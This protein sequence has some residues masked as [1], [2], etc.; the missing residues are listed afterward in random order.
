MRDYTTFS[1]GI[2]DAQADKTYGWVADNLDSLGLDY[3]V[4]HLR[5]TL[6]ASDYYVAGYLSVIFS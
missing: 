1:A 2:A 3:V 4:N 6:G 5:S